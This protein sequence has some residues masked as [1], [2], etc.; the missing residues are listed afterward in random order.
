[1]CPQGS[2]LL[3]YEIYFTNMGLV[4]AVTLCW[5]ALQSQRKPFPPALQ[6][7]TKTSAI[8]RGLSNVSAV[9]LSICSRV[10]EV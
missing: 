7:G 2:R 3:Q 10:C 6:P 5:K 1:M 9:R 8:A 4:T